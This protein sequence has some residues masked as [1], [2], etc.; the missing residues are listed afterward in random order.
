MFKDFKCAIAA[1]ALGGTL[2]SGAAQA[3]CWDSNAIEAAQVH[4][5]ETMLMVASLRCRI[6]GHD[7]LPSYNA[8]VR[9]SRPTLAAMNDRLRTHFGDLNSYDRYVTSVANRYGGGTAGLDCGDMA[10]ILKEARGAAGSAPVLVKIARQA[11]IQPNL[12]GSA[13]PVTIARAR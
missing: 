8:F 10:S 11:G 4:D 12:P 3:A 1:L 9:G 7:F 5:L 13:C 2:A 6:G